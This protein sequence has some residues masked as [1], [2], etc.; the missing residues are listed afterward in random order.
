MDPLRMMMRAKRLAQN[1]PGWRQIALYGGVIAASLA[2]AG[3]E[4]IWGW[5]DWLTPEKLK[6]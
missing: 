3:I 1:P 4:L 5:P 2:V 6:P